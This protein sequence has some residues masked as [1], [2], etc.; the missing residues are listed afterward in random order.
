MPRPYQTWLPCMQ[1]ACDLLHQTGQHE[2][3]RGPWRVLGELPRALVVVDVRCPCRLPATAA[4][5][6]R[7]FLSL[8]YRNRSNARSRI[9]LELRGICQ[10]C[11][12]KNWTAADHKTG[13][14]TGRSPCIPCRST[15]IFTSWKRVESTRPLPA[16]N[17]TCPIQA[18]GY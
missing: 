18:M 14:G 13:G 12:L 9:E 6:Q 16:E 2:L 15:T 3:R 17:P 7:H 4:V 5:A 1:I 8:S 11:D 10:R